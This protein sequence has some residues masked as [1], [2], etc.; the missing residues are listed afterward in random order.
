M[1]LTRKVSENI[2][3][4]AKNFGATKLGSETGLV[5][6]S[7]SVRSFFSS[8][9]AFIVSSGLIRAITISSTV[10]YVETLASGPARKVNIEKT[11]LDIAQNIAM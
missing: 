7:C 1:Q 5:R 3:Y 9:N 6:R 4:D 10:K 8:E 11:K 2:V